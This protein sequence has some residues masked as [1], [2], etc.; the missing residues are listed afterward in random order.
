MPMS[1]SHTSAY[2]AR[3]R[4]PWQPISFYVGIEAW[5]ELKALAQR[6]RIPQ[7]VLL[8]EAVGDLLT[9]HRAEVQK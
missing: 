4:K 7:A 6:T 9:K 3:Y 8:R 1:K 2:N 5:K